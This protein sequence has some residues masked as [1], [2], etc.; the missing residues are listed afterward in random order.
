[1]RLFLAIALVC[2]SIVSYFIERIFGGDWA[3]WNHALGA[4]A[5]VWYLI[6]FY[7]ARR[8]VILTGFFHIYYSIGMLLSAALVSG[9]MYMFEVAEFGDQNGIFWVMMAYFV[10]GLEVSNLGY[11]LGGF[12]HFKFGVKKLTKGTGKLFILFVT[13]TTLIISVYVFIKYSGPIL[14]GIDRVTFWR[15]FV[16]S[17]LSF[18]P[19]LVTQSFFF[20]AFYFLWSKR[21]EYKSWLPLVIL[22]SYVLIGLFVL[23][24]K[25]SLFMLFITVWFVLLPGVFPNFI[26]K[27]SHMIPLFGVVAL[28]TASVLV[29]YAAQDKEAG[30]AIARIAL[31]SQL[32]WSVFDDANA[33]NFWSGDWSCYFG[34]GQFANGVNFISY[35]YLPFGT[36]KFYSDNGTILS[37]FMPALSIVTMGIATSLLIHLT[38][39]FILG[40][41]Q[42]KLLFA[43]SEKNIVYSFLLYKTH[44][45]M[46]LIWFAA[47]T[48]AI[49]GLVAVLL[50]IGLYRL[51]FS[52][53]RAKDRSPGMAS[54][55]SIATT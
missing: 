6:F 34:C 19:T 47:M 36:Y 28:L 42:R 41:L 22:V 20:V 1:M 48:T 23:G 12:F 53:S 2:Y 40:I 9:G 37:G 13:I 21:D 55:A 25:L 49:P 15:E 18:V 32:L 24:Q 43:I 44:I 16:P 50:L 10:S 17:Y 11:R 39:S 33:H 3:N 45:G 30:F 26:I 8:E 51:S 35:K 52:V 46:T 14:L 7:K 54:A 29:S 38:I 5:L 4:V 27:R 31:Q